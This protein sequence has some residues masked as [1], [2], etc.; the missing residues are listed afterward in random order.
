MFGKEGLLKKKETIFFIAVL[1]IIFSFNSC[2]A[3]NSIIKTDVKIDIYEDFTF[4][5]LITNNI[6]TDFWSTKDWVIGLGSEM[7]NVTIYDRS[8]LITPKEITPLENDYTQYIID[9]HYGGSDGYKPIYIQSTRNSLEKINDYMH[10]VNLLL[11]IHNGD[12]SDENVT[13]TLNF[14][15]SMYFPKL[16]E[17]SP[18]T[19]SYYNPNGYFHFMFLNGLESFVKISDENKVFYVE[20]KSLLINGT[21]RAIKNRDCILS[22]PLYEKDAIIISIGNIKELSKNNDSD[23][24]GIYMHDGWIIVDED[25]YNGAPI[26][27]KVGLVV[28][29][30]LTHY[31]NYFGPQDNYPQWLEEGSAVYSSIKYAERTFDINNLSDDTQLS[32]Y[33]VKPYP[34]VLTYWY[35]TNKNFYET[36]YSYELP[37][38]S[39]YSLYGFVINH[40]AQT[41]GEETLVSSLYELKNKP[42]LWRNESDNSDRELNSA[43]IKSL[44]VKS[45]SNISEEDLFFPD[46]ALFLSNYTQFEEKMNQFLMPSESVVHYP[47][48]MEYLLEGLLIGLVVLFIL[49]VVFVL[50]ILLLIFL[51]KKITSK[52]KKVKKN[53]KR[54][55]K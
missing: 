54:F 15:K 28:L 23:A 16:A 52:K 19:F 22:Y 45:K 3:R 44:L 49:F 2:Q 30:E 1:F 51:I 12:I 37:S 40:Y 53:I 50:P 17:E 31:S 6:D 21:Q 42:S 36:N 5:I 27:E 33:N 20:N 35:D 38:G 34:S 13:V 39:L 8:G 55:N 26:E 25:Y 46:R 11:G 47:F 9:T 43:A 48:K 7:Q 32:L 14:P 29:H 10:K 4:D 41:Y 24:I 18:I